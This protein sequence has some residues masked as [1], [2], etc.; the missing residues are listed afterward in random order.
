MVDTVQHINLK[1]ISNLS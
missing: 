1:S